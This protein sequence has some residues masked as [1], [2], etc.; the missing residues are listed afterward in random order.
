MM[1]L[2]H[3]ALETHPGKAIKIVVPP[4]CYG[5]TNDQARR[6]AA[7]IDNVEIVDLPV[8]GGKEM[9]QSIDVVLDKIAS[10]DAIPYIIAEIP[11]NPRVEVPDL[12]KLKE[13]LSKVRKTTTGAT[14]IG[15][16]FILDQTFCPNVHFLG[17]GEILSTV[18]TMC[19]V[20][21]RNP[22]TEDV[23]PYAPPNPDS[24]AFT[25]ASARV[26]TA[27]LSNTML[28]TLRTVLGVTRIACAISPLLRP[29]ARC[30]R[31]SVSRGVRPCMSAL[32]CA[33]SAK[34]SSRR[35][36]A[37]RQARG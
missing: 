25:M 13:V 34:R 19:S 10:E 16:M 22:G 24:R 14:A 17:E 7:S 3:D 4:N 27:N 2:I 5:G 31:S 11:T 30:S 6:I 1:G 20:P 12:L 33:S 15:P 35:R 36:T 8:D 32:R 26:R 21:A 18:R 37:R 29:R 9:D 28:T 23:A